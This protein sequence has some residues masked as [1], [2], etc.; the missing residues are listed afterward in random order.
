MLI[1]SSK[2]RT[3]AIIGAGYSGTLTA[4]NILRTSPPDTVRVVLVEQD[5][6]PGRGLAYRFADDNHLLNV[7]A[8]NMSALA[9]EPNH[10]VGYC[11]DVDPAF[12]TGSFVPRTLYGEY[13]QYTLAET[14]T[15]H[16]GTL[17]KIK[18]EAIAIRPDASREKFRI[19]LAGGAS[20][21][22]TQVV[23]AFGHFSPRPPQSVPANLHKY[24]INPWDFSALDGL[25]QKRPV[26]ILGTGHTAVDV[27]FRLTSCNRTRK[28]FLLSR[29][30]LLPHGHRFN[31]TPQ[32][33]CEYP[34]YLVGLPPTIRAYTRALRE[35]ATRREAA[36]GNWR[37]VL[38]ELRPHTP[39]LW[40]ALP[41][42]ERIR[43]LQKILPYWDVHRHRLA[44][45]AAR[46]LENLLDSGQVERMAGRITGFD[47]EG[48]DLIIQFKGRGE[49]PVEN[50]DVGAVVNCTG[51]NNDLSSLSLPL[52]TQLRNEGLI[53]QDRL[54]L[55][56]LVDDDYRVIDVHDQSNP[57]LFY[58]GP[59]LKTRYWE[60]TAVPELRAH[61]RRLAGKLMSLEK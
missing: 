35:E 53:Q 59:M 39:R 46:R 50:L 37:D 54:K 12:N 19:E 17:E 7:P 42:A 26:A 40:R 18:G 10:F 6:T 44:P 20:L 51:P 11:Q 3:I 45:A 28:I 22:A 56:L 57:G 43:S 1:P 48:A 27:L 25:D 47:R 23:L 60:A 14:E 2:E 13:L 8:G 61:T 32:S 41:E 55:G 38:N 9:D 58:V 49:A 15:N 33:A 34:A 52:V 5:S 24:L 4:V 31:P 36:G 21:E 29:R 16:P 30:G